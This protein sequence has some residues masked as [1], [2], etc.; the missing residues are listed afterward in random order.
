MK[1]KWF[2]GI[3]VAVTVVCLALSL[4]LLWPADATAVEVWS[5]GKLV[6]TLSLM[7]DQTIE[8]K[9]AQGINVVTVQ[10]GKV[11]VT[12]ADCPDKYCMHRGWCSG[13]MQIV[14]LPNRLVLKFTGETQYD[15]VAG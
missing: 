11:A 3:I 10:D 12:S 8:V 4:W 6:Q 13:G 2:V 14:C 7:Q 5:E 15:G 9:T 1:T